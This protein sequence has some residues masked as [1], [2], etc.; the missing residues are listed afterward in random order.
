MAAATRWIY[1]HNQYRA[2][3]ARDLYFNIVCLRFH[4]ELKFNV[5]TQ[6]Q[7]KL[8]P[9]R[10]FS[11]SLRKQHICQCEI[12]TWEIVDVKIRFNISHQNVLGSDCKKL[13]E[14]KKTYK[15]GEYLATFFL[16]IFYQKEQRNSVGPLYLGHNTH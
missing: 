13:V 8:T 9:P 3:P 4:A 6:K 14:I 10:G 5:E 7:L 16:H 1:S 2:F 12:S 11:Q 15:M